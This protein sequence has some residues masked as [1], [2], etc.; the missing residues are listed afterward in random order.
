[1][2]V[3]ITAARADAA[4]EVSYSAGGRDAA[5]VFMGGTE[6]RALV[7]YR[8]K[9]YAGNGYWEDRP[10]EEGRQGAEILV[11]DALDARWRVEH[12]FGEWI[13]RE[14]RRDLAISALGGATFETDGAGAALR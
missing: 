5:G 9:L 2:A 13:S 8:G 10:G 6:L 14:R 7:S 1:M 12:V 11:L 3:D 4:V